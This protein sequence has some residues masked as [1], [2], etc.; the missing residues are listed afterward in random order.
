ME[1]DNPTSGKKTQCPNS[2][3]ISNLPQ[4]IIESILSLMP[5]RDALRTSILSKKWRYSWRS[6]PKLTFTNSL[7]KLPSN[8]G[9]TQLKSKLVTA[10][11]HVLLLHNGPEILHFNC[12]FDHMESE[13]TQ[14]LSYLARGN[15]VKELVLAKN[16][17]LYKL[18]FSFFS[19]QGLECIHLQNCIFEPP[20]PFNKFSRL[21]R[22]SFLNVEISFQMLRLFF[23]KCPL[24]VDLSLV[25]NHLS[26]FFTSIGNKLTFVDILQFVPLIRSLNVSNSYVTYMSAGGM[27]HKLP[28]LL[29]HLKYLYLGVCLTKQN[30][31]S[32]VLCMIR[33][34]PV[35]ERIKFQVN[36]AF[37]DENLHVRQTLTDVLDPEYYRDLKLDRLE[38]LEIQMINSLH[39]VT[40][41]F[42]KLIM[43]NSPVLKIVLI[44]LYGAISVDEEV[45]MLRDLVL[46]P[47]PRASPSAKLIV[48]RRR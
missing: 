21:T 22:M 45:K 16:A 11:F 48:A 25:T 33:S 7:V 34:S 42:V 38:K 17:G 43:A 40:M 39:V 35:L 28:T 23:C 2:D 14:I 26:S 46:L 8:A 31:M 9:S 12:S 37:D 32:S 4:N 5:L 10:I 29:V 47:F 44:V 24:L 18:P 30:E 41:D 19:L 36:S 20:L 27:P 13:I 1:Y 3:M 6:M 15:M